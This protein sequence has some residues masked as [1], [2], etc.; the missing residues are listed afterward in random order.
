MSRYS[1]QKNLVFI[2]LMSF[3]FTLTNKTIYGQSLAP[4]FF[5]QPPGNPATRQ[6]L[7]K[8]RTSGTEN[9]CHGT[10]RTKSGQ[11]LEQDR[12]W[13]KKGLID[14]LD[15]LWTKCGQDKLWTKCGK[16]KL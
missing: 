14:E 2:R 12:L 8:L 6:K 16:D 10:V 13:T 5:C 3:L 15:I 11:S 4:T 9:L 1:P 7:D